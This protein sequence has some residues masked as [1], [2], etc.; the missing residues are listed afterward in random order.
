MIESPLSRP[1][2]ITPPRGLLHL[3]WRELWRFRELFYIFVWRDIKVRYKQTVLGVAWVVFQ[4]L[5]TMGIFT[6][7]FGYLA[8][9]PSHGIPYPI[10]VYTGLLFWNYYSTAVTLAS[11]SMVDNENIIK[12]IYF[13]RIILPLA[14]A[15][16]PLV[17]FL[18]SL[19]VLFGLMLHYGFMPG[20]TGLLLLPLLIVAVLG[21]AI[22]LSLLTASLNA[23]YRDVRY[24]LP[25]FFQTVFFLTP[26]IYPVTLVPANL[27]WLMYLNPMA[28]II[29]IAR[30]A[31]LRT[32]PIPWQLTGIS[33]LAGVV[34]FV[35]GLTYFRKTE[36]SFADIL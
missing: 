29:T 4:P 7:F 19:T 33:L 34:V 32:G 35:C 13:P 21:N 20:L 14:T 5:I 15:T 27:Q 10:F 17:D 28:G 36:R 25:F 1:Y 16:T 3:D 30:H 12:K 8:K 24:L 22:G 6:L 26:I 31:L 2:D 11:S 18:I 23:R 9:I